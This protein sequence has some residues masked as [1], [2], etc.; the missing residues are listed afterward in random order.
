MVPTLPIASR[1]RR[2]SASHAAPYLGD[3]R[4]DEDVAG[5]RRRDAPALEGRGGGMRGSADADAGAK[6]TFGAASVV[7]VA[8]VAIIPSLITASRGRETGDV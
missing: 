2:V 7:M 6:D 1:C 4:S 8:A 5:L 3:A